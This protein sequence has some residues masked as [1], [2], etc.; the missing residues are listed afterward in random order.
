[1]AKRVN[2]NLRP[3]PRHTYDVEA[4]VI[5]GVRGRPCTRKNPTQYVTVK[6]LGGVALAHLMLWIFAHGPIPDGMEVNHKNGNKQD[7]RACNL[8]LVTSGDNQRHAYRINIKQPPRGE[9]HGESVLTNAQVLEIRRR[10]TAGE[11]YIAL[12]KAY[13]VSPC[14]VA[15]AAQGLS[16]AHLP[17]AVP[18]LWRKRP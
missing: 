10:R 5:Y 18:R 2:H 15:F 16:W 11:T 9:E 4:G 12:A 7:N 13:G 6:T 3:D 1:M 8:E 17:N 14:G